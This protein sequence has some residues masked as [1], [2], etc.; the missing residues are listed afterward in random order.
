[1]DVRVHVLT[2][3]YMYLIGIK[4]CVSMVQT[5]TCTYM[6]FSNPTGCVLYNTF[7]F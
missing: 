5:C 6:Y 3:T 2:C 7:H 4:V 1:M